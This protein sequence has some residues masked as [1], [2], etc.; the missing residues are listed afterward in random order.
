MRVIV[1]FAATVLLVFVGFSTLSA[2]QRLAT[3]WN[4]DDKA[5]SKPSHLQIQSVPLEVALRT[6][7]IRSGADLVY[8]P[9][10][11][12][13]REV[14][15]RCESLTVS[16]ALDILLAQTE[17]DY[18]A[19]NGHVV[20]SPSSELAAGKGRS[21]ASILFNRL[22][23]VPIARTVEL[24]NP[25]DVH[26]MVIQ[27]R[28]ITGTVVDNL[29]NPVPNARVT[30]DGTQ[31]GAITDADGGFHIVRVPSGEVALSVVRIGWRPSVQ[32]VRGGEQ[33]VRIVM[34]RSAVSLD[35]I[36]V[37]GT[38]G[39]VAKRSIGNA[40]GQ[41]DVESVMELAPAQ[42]IGQLLN[43]RSPGVVINTPSGS[44]GSGQHILI[45][46]PSSLS[47]KGN[48][49]IFVDGV[50]VNNDVLR[51]TPGHQALATLRTA[52]VSRLNDFNP[53]DIESIEIIKG[54][55]AA[56]LYGTEA[57]N[58]VIQI[59][60]KRGRPGKTRFGVRI[61]Q[62]AAFLQNPSGTF[63]TNYWRD[64]ATGEVRSLNVIDS[65]AQL[66][67]SVFRTG[68]TQGY[69]LDISGGGEGFLYRLAGNL[70]REEG[71]IPSNDIT[72]FNGTANVSISPSEIVDIS[73]NLAL[74][75][76]DGSFPGGT[77]TQGV[78]LH[79]PRLADS[80]TRGF[81]SRPPEVDLGTTDYTQDIRRTTASLRVDHRPWSWFS[82]RV[83]VGTDLTNERDVSLLPRVPT[84]WE[85]FFSATAQRG[86]KSIER[87]NA[88]YT[89]VDY[90][91]TF[92][93]PITSNLGATS[94]FGLQYYRRFEEFELLSG[95]EFPGTG[96]TTIEG[97]AIRTAAE[98]FVENTTVG[99]YAQ[100]QFSWKNRLFL[101]AAL[102]ADDNSAFGA[103]FDLVTYPKFSTSWVVNEEPFWNVSF[104]NTLRLRAAYGQTGQQPS[105]FASIRSYR[106][107]TA[108]GD[109]AAG[110]PL[111]VGNPDLG[112]ER[113][114]E[115]ELGFEA[116]VFNERLGIDFTF[117]YQRTKDVIVERE[118]APS[119]GF[120]ADQFVNAGEVRN[121]GVEILVTGRAIESRAVDW[122]LSLNL[123]SNSNK[124]LSLGIEDLE[125]LAVGWI[126]NRHQP[127]FPLGSFFQRRIVSADLDAAGNAINVMCD[128]GPG[129]GPV[130]CANAPAVFAGAP[131]PKAEGAFTSTVTL[132]NRL[133]LYAMFDFK[134][135][136]KM[137]DAHRLIP[138][139]LIGIHEINFFPER[140]APEEVAS[141]DLGIGFM[142][143]WNQIQN[144]DFLKFRELSLRYSF[145]ER[146]A[147][148]FGAD[149]ASAT[150]AARNLHTWTGFSGAD[151]EVFTPDNF[152]R[153]DHNQFMLPLPTTLTVTVNLVY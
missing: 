31:L 20:I 94:S 135:G 98:D 83:T 126:P 32:S 118:V 41:I 63:P 64:P 136:K 39:G 67:N 117:Y 2:Q 5:L 23:V 72:R 86:S 10:L 87:K 73:V 33:V 25:L 96:I 1:R 82:H 55:A 142:A 53:A 108:F 147:S 93:Y 69:G 138:C 106:P 124:V 35:E 56:T 26:P 90:S 38:V 17:L 149:R 146:F 129:S 71:V 65:E 107:I 95:Q 37:T 42:D 66:G 88:T 3:G 101:T 152:L 12:P 7:R 15:C 24:A 134:I 151:P 16:A 102:R 114:E 40:V 128:G 120:A 144:T 100:H 139:A 30:V 121:R 34:S 153:S 59:I 9:T 4:K 45:R 104:I 89:T 21:Q 13:D 52:T 99:L 97:T 123:S 14:S 79:T 43:G 75:D 61:R 58:G 76:S 27:E 29:G 36:I 92:R 44:A 77:Y 132:H 140:F 74:L 70:D 119:T 110:S 109:Q 19:V 47:F 49:L 18:V 8:S 62:G 50:R 122:D 105:S 68:H 127:G 137:L 80:P 11:L 125:F 113:G 81:P 130:A 51:G 54:P 116:S 111:F 84:V 78:F 22:G 103:D 112:P 91:G 57:S 143:G 46:G 131:F 133:S 145:P 141:C 48:P 148:S 150:V 6:L 115:V 28:V 60:T 85:Q